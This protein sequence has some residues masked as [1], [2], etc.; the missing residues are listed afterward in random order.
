MVITSSKHWDKCFAQ[1]VSFKS[2]WMFTEC[3]VA[4]VSWSKQ[5]TMLYPLNLYSAAGQLYLYKTGRKYK[6]PHNN[7]LCFSTIVIHI[8]KDVETNV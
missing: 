1:I 7:P 5:D 8:F 4:T 6:S 2:S 3:I